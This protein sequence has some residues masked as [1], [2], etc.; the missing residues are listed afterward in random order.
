MILVGSGALVWRAALHAASVGKSVDLVIHPA[1]EAVPARASG[2]AHIGTD[3]VNGLARVI[4]EAS[5]DRLVC[6]TG[7]PFIFREPVLGLGLTIVNV[8]GAPLPAYRGLPL[9]AAAFAILRSEPEFG[10]TLHRVDAGIDT[11]PVVARRTF[12]VADSTTLE[13]LSVEVSQ[14]CHEI[15][16]DNVDDLA[17]APEPGAGPDGPGEY[18]GM[19]RLASIGEHRDLPGFTRA[20]ELGVLEDH[21]PEY[22][23]AFAAAGRGERA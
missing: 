11:G 16:V 12:P 7:N 8:H 15:F 18:F 23:A 4:D 3:D 21:Y 20:T 22:A 10:V 6:S 13:E 1:D 2:F 19:R 14:A 9:V 5:S 17:R